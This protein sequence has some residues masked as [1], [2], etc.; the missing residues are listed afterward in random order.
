MTVLKSLGLAR[1]SSC[2]SSILSCC[3]TQQIISLKIIKHFVWEM[4]LKKSQ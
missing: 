1:S 4:D 2:Y 3:E